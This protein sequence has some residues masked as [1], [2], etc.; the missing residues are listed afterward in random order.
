MKNSHNLVLHAHF[1]Y[2]I[3]ALGFLSFRARRWSF[4]W[5]N[6]LNRR[7]AY[8]ILFRNILLGTIDIFYCLFEQV[9]QA[10]GL[11]RL[12]WWLGH[13]RRNKLLL[14]L[15]FLLLLFRLHNKFDSHL[16]SIRQFASQIRLF[17]IIRIVRL[18]IVYLGVSL[19][20]IADVLIL[21]ILSFSFVPS[22]IFLT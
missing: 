1:L 19:I 9:Q 15:F 8:K 16:M 22:C 3:F 12:D 11:L 2:S 4:D 5:F 7:F 17:A 13:G 18:L 21:I 14:F 10:S 20:F 6:F